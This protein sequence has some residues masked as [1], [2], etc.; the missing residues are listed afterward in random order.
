MAGDPGWVDN[1]GL[2]GDVLAARGGLG[3]TERA[4]R[5]IGK[6]FRWRSS[7]AWAATSPTL[8][9]CRRASGR[10]RPGSR[11]WEGAFDGGTAG[12]SQGQSVGSRAVGGGPAVAPRQRRRPRPPVRLAPRAECV[13]P[14]RSPA[15][16]SPEWR[17]GSKGTWC[18]TSARR[19]TP[20]IRGVGL[21]DDR[22]PG[23]ARLQHCARSDTP[24]VT[25]HAQLADFVRLAA[26][27]LH[28]STLI[29]GRIAVEGDVNAGGSPICSASSAD[30]R[31]LA[32]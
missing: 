23:A 1:P 24:A 16:S 20:P 17:S 13:V 6:P 25:I 4:L 31:A 11:R 18:S 22:D 3:D 14:G 7:W 9:R 21:V 27:D 32:G 5:L 29:G 15:C 30:R 19:T 12:T 10:S 26:G 8:R 2:V 28:Q